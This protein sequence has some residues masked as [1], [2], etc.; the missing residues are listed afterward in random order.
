MRTER[1]LTLTFSSLDV[2]VVL[3]QIS[4]YAHVDVLMTPGAKGI[5]SVNIRNR[6][7]DDAIRL[8]TAVAGLSM[9]KVGSAYVVGPAEEVAKAAGEFGQVDVVP[10]HWITPAE[11]AA[12]L[13]RLAPHVSVLPAKNGIIISGLPE[14]LVLAHAAL[15]SL[16]IEPAPAPAPPSDSRVITLLH[17]VPVSAQR[18]INEAYPDLKVSV[19]DRTLILTGSP[20]ALDSAVKAVQGFD[21]QA[22]AVVEANDVLVYRLKYLNAQRTEESIKKAFPALT[23]TVAPE[24]NAPPAAVFNPLNTIFGTGSGDFATNTTTTSTAPT[25]TTTPTGAGGVTPQPLSRPTRIILVGPKS[26]IEAA[27]DVLVQTD[28]PQP[29]VRI[30]AVMIEVDR[31]DTQNLGITWDFTN[32]GF[33]FTEPAGNNVTFGT[34]QRSSASFATSLQALFTQNK[35]KILASP[36]VSVVDNEDASIFIGDMIR[37]LGGT[38]TSL[39]TTI[40]NVE[41]LPVGIALLM[42][43]RIHPDGSVT[44]KVHPVISTVTGTVDGLPQTSSREADTTVRLM[45]GEQMVI[46]GLDRTDVTSVLN[47]VPILGDIPILKEFFTTRTHTTDKTE[48]IIILRAYAATTEA[49]PAHPFSS[50]VPK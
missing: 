45:P 4:S 33:T 1:R 34:V 40:Q 17:V 36:N 10:L 47:K 14:D 50:G 42:R 27:K 43:P 39:G 2:R 38:A 12:G 7:A 8:V 35:A 6:T 9:V 23:V 46:G 41:A 26:E 30:E 3:D 25:T 44:L 32:T 16:D 24:A 20:V 22:L 28:V 37:Y 13:A 21:V 49:A 19:E 15:P 48:V 11:A 29:S 5:V 31:T 18:I